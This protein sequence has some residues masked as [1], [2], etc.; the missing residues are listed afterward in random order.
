MIH[1]V[2]TGRWQVAVTLLDVGEDLEWLVPLRLDAYLR[3]HATKLLTGLE[4]ALGVRLPR[5]LSVC[6]A[7]APGR[8]RSAAN[9]H[10]YLPRGDRSGVRTIERLLLQVAA[11]ADTADRDAVALH[12]LVCPVI[13]ETID[14]TFICA[15]KTLGV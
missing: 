14:M 12:G 10:Y 3:P 6:L 9:W 2:T 11:D 15:I 7:G 5:T 8:M 13:E 1:H 4:E